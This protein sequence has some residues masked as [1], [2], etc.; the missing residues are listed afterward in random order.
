MADEQNQNPKKSIDQEDSLVEGLP[1]YKS[2]GGTE[3]VAVEDMNSTMMGIDLSSFQAETR[4]NIRVE[5]SISEREDVSDASSVKE[6]APSFFK[7][8]FSKAKK[9]IFSP[10]SQYAE[11]KTPHEFQ[12]PKRM[13]AFNG[14]WMPF[15]KDSLVQKVFFYVS[16]FLLVL[17]GIFAQWVLVR[18]FV[19]N[20]QNMHPARWIVLAA[21]VLSV[22]LTIVSVLRKA[23][24]T[25][26]L[27]IPFTALA[28]V[29][30]YGAWFYSTGDLYYFVFQNQSLAHWLNIYY[31]GLFVFLVFLFV[32]GQTQS[33]AG[34]ILWGVLLLLSLVTPVLHQIYGVNFEQGLAGYG[35]IAKIEQ[36]YLRPAYLLLHAL[37]P[38]WLVLCLVKSFS[39]SLEVRKKLAQSVYLSLTPLFWAML[40]LSLALLQNNRIFHLGNFF[41]SMKPI[42]GKAEFELMG[43]RVVLQVR[44]SSSE[45]ESSNRYTFKVSGTANPKQFDLE[46]TNADQEAVLGLTKNEFVVLTDDVENSDFQL[47]THPTNPKH[48]LFKLDLKAKDQAINL[49]SSKKNWL[50]SED[51]VLDVADPLQISKVALIENGQSLIEKSPP[52][53]EKLSFTLAYF[54]PGDHQ[55][56]VVAYDNKNQESVR[57]PF[58]I[59]IQESRN[60]FVVTPFEGDD[61]SQK[62]AVYLSLKAMKAQ[63]VKKITYRLNNEVVLESPTYSSFVTLDATQIADGDVK[64]QIQID[65][66]GESLVQTLNLRKSQK[67]LGNLNVIAPAQGSFAQNETQVAY[68]VSEPVNAKVLGVRVKVN[69]LPY[70]DFEVKEN[71]F[72]LPT[73]RWKSG[74]VF[75]SLQATLDSGQKVSDWVQ[76]NRGVSALKLQ[77]QTQSLLFLGQKKMSII[78]DSS[79]ST[80]DFWYSKSL[81]EVFKDAILSPEIQNKL[82]E[83]ELNL[84]VFGGDKPS[85]YQNCNAVSE[86]FSGTVV[87]ATLKKKLDELVSQGQRPLLRAVTKALQAKPNKLVL[88]TGGADSCEKSWIDTFTQSLEKSN[89]TKVSLFW[90]GEKLPDT[91]VQKLT[92]ALQKTGGEFF[93]AEDMESFLKSFSDE[94]SVNFELAETDKLLQRA[95][96]KDMEIN[97]PPGDYTLRLPFTEGFKEVPV[98]LDHGLKKVL[99]VSGKDGKLFVEESAI[100]L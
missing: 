56:T 83:Q 79:Q 49:A 1:A 62:I 82:A 45:S 75:I 88:I 18:S 13:Q 71:R 30:A 85:Y 67:A 72:S 100:P 95:P 47:L 52:F 28:F 23:S 38:L 15:A 43:H 42:A 90:F 48:Y 99:N 92:L 7:R 21:V 57:I 14:V 73:A 97:L 63:D 54:N 70:E 12:M 87:K 4:Q 81:L 89:Q 77:F 98:H 76:V 66:E 96:L 74:E 29:F 19:S 25:W 78:L 40:V 2:S 61:V 80:S 91:D 20:Y 68:E 33:L 44:D 60:F 55:L 3:E 69:G 58:K 53:A 22:L 65:Q 64:L 93:D 9:P 36:F 31:L 50:Q 6:K 86:V 35:V 16:R 34:K 27:T 39:R 84:S 11:E 5:T 51:L 46:I 10:K 24:P 59:N 32:G 17:C 37:I 94:L 8:L 26:I 41:V